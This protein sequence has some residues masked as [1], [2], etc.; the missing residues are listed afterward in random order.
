MKKLTL[1][2]ILAGA[3]LFFLAAFIS[4]PP[5]HESSFPEVKDILKSACFDCHSDVATSDKAKTALDFD[6]WDNYKVTRK[7][8]KLDAICE[9]VSEDKMP[10]EKYLKSKPDRKLSDEQKKAICEWTEKESERLLE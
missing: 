2:F 8:A 1:R 7:I 6:Q 3:A 9:V 10:P 5:A 4:I